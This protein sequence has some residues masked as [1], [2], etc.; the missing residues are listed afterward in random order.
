[1]ISVM[2]VE[3]LCRGSVEATKYA[4]SLIEALI[5]DTDKKFEHQLPKLKPLTSSSTQSGQKQKQSTANGNAKASS[6]LVNGVTTNAVPPTKEDA[7]KNSSGKVTTA[8]FVPSVWGQPSAAI[9]QSKSKSTV[10]VTG[11]DT[12]VSAAWNAT[13]ASRVA[14]EASKMSYSGRAKASATSTGSE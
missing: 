14:Q 8:I 6:T 3:F 10:T 1:M 2:I 12:T 9:L 7:L 11:T 4:Q 5:N 13:S